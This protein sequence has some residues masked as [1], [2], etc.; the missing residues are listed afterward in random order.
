[1]SLKAIVCKRNCRNS[2]RNSRKTSNANSWL[3]ICTKYKNSDRSNPNSSRPGLISTKNNSKKNSMW[4]NKW[5]R[6]KSKWLKEKNRNMIAKCNMSESALCTAKWKTF[7]TESPGPI[8][9]CPRKAPVPRRDLPLPGPEIFTLP[10]TKENLSFIK[11]KTK[12]KNGSQIIYSK[13][14]TPKAASLKNKLPMRNA[15]RRAS[16]VMWRTWPR[17]GIKKR[18]R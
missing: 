6:W 15:S 11:H 9:P 17:S 14:N 1:M 16:R 7:K 5:V 4:S 13:W 2:L 18:R 12:N 8:L 10:L 3:M